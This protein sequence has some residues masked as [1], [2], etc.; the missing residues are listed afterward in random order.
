MEDISSMG[1]AKM[2]V[3][4][5][6]MML[7]ASFAATGVRA[8][9]PLILETITGTV[10]IEINPLKNQLIVLA[11]HVPIRKYPI[12]LGKPETPTPAGDFV[13]VNKY[14]HWGSGFGTRWLGL[15]VPW[16]T[17]GIHGT[18]RPFSIGHDASHGCIRMLNRHVEEIYE[19]VRVGTKV[20]ILGHVLGEPH[21][22]PRNLAKGDSGGDVLL[23]QSRLRS[24]GLFNGRCNGRFDTL[25]EI[26][27][28]QHEK[29]NSLQV[30]GVV[31]MKDY[32]SFGLVE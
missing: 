8:A 16:G 28:K 31:S 17:Y 18:N 6:V 22:N 23:I 5:C 11:D 15:N 21:L 32:I 2:T 14:K 20:S 9:E 27:M 10:S 4:V 1:F 24:E 7:Y 26:A 3:A 25:T 13:I 30:D 19:V 29:M 12:A